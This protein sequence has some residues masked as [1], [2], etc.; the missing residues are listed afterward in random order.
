MCGFSSFRSSFSGDFF[1]LGFPGFAKA[2]TRKKK[3][4][5]GFPVRF[6]VACTS[7]LRGV[8]LR[9]P[10]SSAVLL[11]VQGA[12]TLARKPRGISSWFSFSLHT[13]IRRKQTKTIDST[14]D[15]ACN[16]VSVSCEGYARA[17]ILRV[18]FY[19]VTRW[20]PIWKTTTNS[21]R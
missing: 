3:K 1:S 9:A 15:R 21:T 10:Q 20:W 6:S 14:H 11:C 5:R 19:H 2:K 7:K 17:R 13:Y 12:R 18:R 16:W 4:E 8:A